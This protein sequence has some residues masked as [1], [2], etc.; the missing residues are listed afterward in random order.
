MRTSAPIFAALTLTSIS[1]RAEQAAP[2]TG[3][4][5]VAGDPEPP[6]QEAPSRKHDGAGPRLTFGRALTQTVADGFY[7]RFESE[8]FEAG[9][10]L[11]GGALV[12]LEGWGCREGGGGAI[13]MSLFWG[14]RVPFFEGPKAPRFMATVGAGFDFAVF[15]YVKGDG[16][17][18]VM[19]PFAT[20][21]VGFEI[22]PGARVLGDVRAQYRWL[23]DAPD[24]YQI[25]VGISLA[26]NSD[27][28]DGPR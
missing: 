4:L 8:Y 9:D 21:V 7:G 26:A 25:R 18:G 13:P 10:I 23:W 15:D 5:Q 12:G 6:R 22:A 24:R 19:A 27:W 2:Q 20:G 11:I 17:F 14:A 16:G 3:A 28:W 1:S